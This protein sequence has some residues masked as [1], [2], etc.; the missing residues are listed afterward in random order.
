[1]EILSRRQY[2]IY[3]YSVY[4]FA[5]NIP[6]EGERR[7]FDNILTGITHPCS[8]MGDGVN[9]CDALPFLEIVRISTNANINIGI[10]EITGNRVSIYNSSGG[11][12][13]VTTGGGNITLPSGHIL[14]MRYNGATWIYSITLY[15]LNID[16]D[17][18]ITNNLVVGG[19][20]TGEILNYDTGWLLNEMGGAGVADWANV[21]L[22]TDPTDP[23]DNLTHNLNAPLSELNVVLLVSTD[24]T[25]ANSF[26]PTRNSYTGG[27]AIY[28]YQINAV[29]NNNIKIQTGTHGIKTMNDDGTVTVISNQNWYYKIKI[30]KLG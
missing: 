17:V 26:I 25:D 19:I 2:T 15:N 6:L 7:Y 3:D 18:N 23:T 22:G 1:M 10:L 8:V 24:G 13:T 9:Q 4:N 21:H 12:I 27:T 5:A 29:D 11:N 30:W 14:K 20:I 16:N 28:G